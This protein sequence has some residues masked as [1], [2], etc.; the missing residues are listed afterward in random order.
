M[1]RWLASPRI[2]WLA[3]L[4][5]LLWLAPTTLRQG[6]Q[7]DD[8][9]HRLSLAKDERFA[10]FVRPPLDLFTFY[11]GDPARTAHAIDDGL[12]PWWTDPALRA[13]FYRP[14]SAATHV[15]DETIAP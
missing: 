6:Y 3:A 10:W 14:V 7:A 9:Y 15:L 11:D 8:Y 1:K 13:S 12:A 4:A 2:V 5:A